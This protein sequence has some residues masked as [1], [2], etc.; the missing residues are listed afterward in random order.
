[1]GRWKLYLGMSV[2]VLAAS[3]SAQDT[4]TDYGQ[5]RVLGV[6][7]LDLLAGPGT[8]A[9][10]LAPDGTQFAH[11]DRGTVCFF[12][13]V[14]G[15]W[16][17]DR[18]VDLA[19]SPFDGAP[20][21]ERWSPD[22]RYLTAPTFRQ[23]LMLLEETDIQVLDT[24]TGAVT[25]LTED[26]AAGSLFS[27][28]DWGTFD[29]APAWL[30]NGT[31]RFIRYTQDDNPLADESVLQSISGAVFEVQL[32]SG[33]ETPDAR[34]VIDLPVARSVGSYLL[35]LDP[36]GERMAVN[37]DRIGESPHHFEVWQ[38]TAD[39]ERFT[40]LA[41]LE[42][43][44]PSL[45]SYSANGEWLFTPGA[46][47]AL[48][49]T[50]TGKVVGPDLESGGFSEPVLAGAGWAPTGEALVYLVHDAA[51]PELSG[52]YLAEAPGER[53]RLILPGDY[54]GTTC[55]LRMPIRWAANDLILL[56]RG[57][58]PGVLLVQVGP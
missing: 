36:A 9:A 11:F 21:D 35:A 13:P 54:Y 51:K 15:D 38:A 56:G 19:D 45:L 8:T 31:L 7:E 48:I 37:V 41:S 34:P 3:V 55:C 24:E 58:Q 25:N 29:L 17:E 1:M 40:L 39:D 10:H 30:E 49:D 18:C 32:P 52:L 43:R 57:S 33:G 12:E 4:A 20:E 2:L 23:A 42:T 22:S 46:G 16:A 53:G 27:K 47:I 5:Y 28:E 14:A 6:Q 50:T 26:G 44:G